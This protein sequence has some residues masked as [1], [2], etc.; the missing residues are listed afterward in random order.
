MRYDARRWARIQEL[1]HAACELPAADRQAWLEVECA[2]TP[3]LVADVLLLLDE[4][5]REES[6]LDRDLAA[7]AHDVLDGSV[8]HLESVGSYRIRS[9][10]GH[11]G[12]GVVYLAE[13]DDLSSK[14]AIKVL[15]DASLSPARRERFASEQRTLAQLNHPAIARLYDAN[16]LPDGTPYFIM[17][18]V[19]GMP[20]TAYCDAHAPTIR[21]RLALFRAV[22]EAVQAAHRQAV[23]HRDL[24]ASNILVTKE[25]TPKLLDFGIAK[26]LE[27]LDTDV[28]RTQTGL[29]LMTPAYAA[30][31]Q[32]RGEAVGTYTDI[33]A[34]G[35]ILYELLAGRLPFDLSNRTPAQ[36]EKL[37]T[38]EEP[39]PPSEA[40]RERSGP[41]LT[42]GHG[43]SRTAWSDLDVLCLTAMHK[44]P[45]RRYRTVWA[46][47]HDIDRF[48][49][50]EPLEARPDS[51]GYRTGKFV[52][53]NWRGLA[54][55][56]AIVAGIVT[57]VIF[58]TMR[59]AGAR[60][61]ALAEA[62]RTQRILRFTQNLFAGGDPEAGPAD[63]LRV[64]TLIGRGV[65]EAALLGRDPALQAELYAT[66]GTLYQQLGDFDRADS[67][68]SLAL[69]RRR[70][71]FGADHADVASSEV[72]LGLLRVDQ[73][74]LDD[75]EHLIR[76]ALDASERRLPPD[77]PDG[78]AARLALARVLQEAGKYDEAIPLYEAIARIQTVTSPESIELSG[79][80]AELAN[81]HFY[82]GNDE[83]SDSLNRIVLD[84]DRRLHGDQHPNVADALI[85]LGTI[86]FNRGN[87]AEAERLDRDALEIFTAWYGEDHYKSAS[88]LKIVGQAVLYQDRDTEADALL[89]C[90][91]GIQERIYGPDHP[92]L[93]TTLND[94]ST[95][96][97]QRGDFD[98][99]EAGYR[100]M[101]DIYRA[102]LG[103]RHYFVAT[104]FSNL[105]SV[106]L[107]RGEFAQSEA[108]MRDV[109]D[110]YIEARGAQDM[111]TGIAYIRLGRALLRQKR[112]EE[113][114][115]SS[116]KG[117]D[118]LKPQTDPGVS[119]LQAARRDLVEAYD[120]LGRP[121]SAATF[122]AE[123]E[124][125]TP[126]R[127]GG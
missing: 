22:C 64:V 1:F 52:R 11:G 62:E 79:T 29:R 111:N 65:Q 44:D 124:R 36:A 15:R 88:A 45:Q 8:P 71:I 84:L 19:D 127:T 5:A 91:F 110:R 54:I 96:A 6:L 55:T 74:E 63:T 10:L 126:A 68:L 60:D 35:V 69:D 58:Y 2:G 122:R 13:R 17:E 51:L 66:L 117:Y 106:F 4:D 89:R 47:I 30:P 116:R 123:L 9:V 86:Q 108:I 101:I 33:Y 12:M 32:V 105:A 18:Y 70:T 72:A 24:K 56:A 112:W 46:F 115:E 42:R 67:L 93:A 102:S 49:N 16:A 120:S 34:L 94:L 37:I 28:A 98:T 121:E 95:I 48:L 57:L 20:L 73:A 7:V 107:Q 78:I 87:Y 40:A 41:A 3:D 23:V 21:E 59:L 80:L 104:A 118:I 27:A 113:A 38:T 109:V 14:E 81:T 85:N 43:M 90:A 99:A 77:H 82:A 75:A 100:R 50:G 61:A 26:Q 125:L 53:R 92:K 31:E 97:M 103:E 119:W 114:Q 76:N 25:G 83:A 39:V